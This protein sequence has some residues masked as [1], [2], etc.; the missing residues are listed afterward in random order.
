[1]KIFQFYLY[2]YLWISLSLFQTINAYASLERIEQ[3]SSSNKSLQIELCKV[4]NKKFSIIFNFIK[5]INKITVRI[6]ISNLWI[7]CDNLI[8]FSS[9]QT[10]IEERILNSGKSL[11]FRKLNG[12]YVCYR[13]NSKKPIKLNM[14]RFSLDQSSDPH[15]NC[16]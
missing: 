2:S 15:K 16:E 12:M 1:M 9:H 14:L 5:P 10:F 6:G 4:E 7:V 3:C 8:N 13:Q 11:R